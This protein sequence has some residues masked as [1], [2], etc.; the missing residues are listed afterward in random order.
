MTYSRAYTRCA[1]LGSATALTAALAA[2]L[3]TAP[4]VRV[5]AAP[6][7]THLVQLQAATL[8][9]LDVTSPLPTAATSPHADSVAAATGSPD[10]FTA[11]VGAAIGAV[12]LPL[13][14]LAFPV[15]LP[16]TILLVAALGGV[17]SGCYSG[18]SYANSN[19]IA[20]IVLPALQYWLTFPIQRIFG[21]PTSSSAAAAPRQAAAV[22]RPEAS[23]NARSLPA[24]KSAV[25]DRSRGRAAAARS[26]TA[27][28]AKTVG[29]KSRSVGASVRHR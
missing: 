16:G 9:S 4:P 12:L 19:P 20:Y 27:R 6:I 5:S 8:S 26:V 29:A 11:I 2:G 22:R 24:S 25:A 23:A 21:V 3:V 10:I 18:Q 7:E 13:W 15:T 1:K 14:Y 28:A 17:C